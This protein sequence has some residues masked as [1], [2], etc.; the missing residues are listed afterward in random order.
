MAYEAQPA[1][2][3]LNLP[4]EL[5]HQI[6]SYL[7]KWEEIIHLPRGDGRHGADMAD[8]VRLEHLQLFRVCRQLRNDATTYFFTENVFAFDLAQRASISLIRD[9]LAERY[10]RQMKQL[11][12]VIWALSVSGLRRPK[13]TF[14]KPG[15]TE[16][17][18]GPYVWSLNSKKEVCAEEHELKLMTP[19]TPNFIAAYVAKRAVAVACE[20]H[21]RMTDERGVDVEFLQY[22]RDEIEPTIRESLHSYTS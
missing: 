11:D 20:F 2:P 3:L 19:T 22:V 4:V 21:A 15:L 5:K 1:T 17:H 12:M 13:L 9:T 16:L 10:I 14:R 6:F 18:I 8:A 7:L